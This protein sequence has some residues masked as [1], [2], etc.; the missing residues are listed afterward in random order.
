MDPAE[1]MARRLS[2]GERPALAR[3]ISW[4]ENGDP[5]F[6]AVL[7]RIY[8]SVGRAWRIGVT[9]PP[10]SGKSSLVNALIETL[11]ERGETVGVLAID[12][13]SP[14]SGGAL[15]GDR[16][17]MEERTTDPGVYIRS[18]ATRASHGGLARA[19]VD[20]LDVMDA[21]GFDWL[22]V[23]TVGV[24]QAEYEIAG[25]ADTVLVVLCPGAGDGVQ[26]MK[27]GLLEVADVLVVNK[28]DL[29][30]ADLVVNDLEDALQLRS[31][32]RVRPRERVPAVVLVSAHTGDG[33]ERLRA[34]ID[35]HRSELTSGDLRSLRAEKRL[36]QVR[37]V[38]GERLEEALWGPAGQRERAA[39]LLGKSR[40]P[41]DV[42]DELLNSILTRM[43]ARPAPSPPQRT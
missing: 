36:R 11:R 17:R 27:A 13:S 4:A 26:A 35:A 8:P 16:I 38:V 31:L 34:A 14:Y 9:G 10:G 28:S 15:L 32:S 7:A 2:A 43:P 18:M 21:F 39:E 30:G 41:Y 5:R 19:A 1:D 25:A 40:T 24:G 29:A 12:P 20:A 37:R 42:A 3:A 6:A 33:L 23:E 22:L